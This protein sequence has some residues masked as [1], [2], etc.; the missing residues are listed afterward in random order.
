MLKSL[1]LDVQ[2]GEVRAI[3]IEDSLDAFYDA[4]DCTCI[5]IVDRCVD[6]RW[7]EIMCDDEGLLKSNWTLSAI[8]KD[9]Q[10]MLVG[11]L[12][13]FHSN[14]EG[15]LA[16]ITE[17]DEAFLREHIYSGIVPIG[18]CGM[19]ISETPMLTKCEYN[20]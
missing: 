12:M 18:T 3:E 20:E 13:F 7:F 8:D 16:S 10:P 2:N 6:G 14:D 11:N 15:D 5:D 4:L 1:L 9:G 19:L 17:D